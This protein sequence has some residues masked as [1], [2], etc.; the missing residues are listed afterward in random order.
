MLESDGILNL[1]KHT[2]DIEFLPFFSLYIQIFQYINLF[3]QCLM[4]RLPPA[5]RAQLTGKWKWIFI[6]LNEPLLKFFFLTFSSNN[7]HWNSSL[8]CFCVNK[9]HQGMRGCSEKITYIIRVDVPCHVAIRNKL[10]VNIASDFTVPPTAVDVNYTDHVP[11]SGKRQNRQVSEQVS[12]S[13][14]PLH[15]S[16]LLKKKTMTEFWFSISFYISN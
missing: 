2:G 8:T 12:F 14:T 15:P 7:N 11:L 10:S 1:C 6:C 3:S 9:Q 5:T 4:F 16:K 13:E